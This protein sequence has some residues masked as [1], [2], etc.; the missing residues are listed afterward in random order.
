MAVNPTWQLKHMSKKW[1]S[2]VQFPADSNYVNRIVSVAFG[3]SN[4][5]GNPM[6]TLETEVVSPEEVEVAG[7]MINIAGV[8]C[9]NYYTTQT[10]SEEKT[11]NSRKR[12]AELLANLGIDTSNL[13][14]DNLAPQLKPLVGKLILTMMTSTIQ[15]RRKNPTAVQM[16]AAKAKGVTNF[17]DVG[18]VMKHPVTGKALI[19]YWPKI[20]EI[21]GLAPEQ[22]AGQ[23]Y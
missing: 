17:R 23:T 15:E 11:A 5:S 7:E 10:D 22:T 13:N 9:K 3:P 6:V 21:F 4:S 8:N 20:D 16:E 1:S 12:L 19:N 18:E 14:W 2:A